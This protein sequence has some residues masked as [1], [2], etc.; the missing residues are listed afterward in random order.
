MGGY[1]F[2]ELIAAVD[3]IGWKR[4]ISLETFMSQD[5]SE[6]DSIARTGIDFL[7]KHFT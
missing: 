4:Y 1:D 6:A 5:E 7:T 3:D 2:S